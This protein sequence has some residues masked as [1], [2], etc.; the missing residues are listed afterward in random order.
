MFSHATKNGRQEIPA[1][2]YHRVCENMSSTS[3]QPYAPCFGS[4][5]SISIV[6]HGVLHT[7][8]RVMRRPRGSQPLAGFADEHKLA[9]SLRCRLL[10]EPGIPCETNEKP[11]GH[12]SNQTYHVSRTYQWSAKKQGLQMPNGTSALGVAA[13]AARCPNQAFLVQQQVSTP[14]LQQPV[15]VV[16]YLRQLL[17]GLYSVGRMLAG[18]T[19]AR[20]PAV[21]RCRRASL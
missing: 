3:A 12:R 17:A 9:M 15:P 11:C 21:C 1:D 5:G 14:V 18:P 13:C 16:R 4:D 2:T 8:P 7:L 10:C 6:Q 19:A 20:L